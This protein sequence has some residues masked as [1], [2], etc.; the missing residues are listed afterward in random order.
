MWELLK[1]L[2]KG[3]GR[4]R[5]VLLKSIHLPVN[6]VESHVPCAFPLVA[7]LVHFLLCVYLNTRAWGSLL[8][9]EIYPGHGSS[10]QKV[11]EY[12]TGI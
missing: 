11:Q 5:F 1:V 8:R 2:Q 9:V 6:L 10:G 7:V 12:G 3:S 4:I